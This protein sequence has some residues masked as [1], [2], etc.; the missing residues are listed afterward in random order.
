MND[1]LTLW[2]FRNSWCDYDYDDDEIRFLFGPHTIANMSGAPLLNSISCFFKDDDAYRKY[3]AHASNHL[4]RRAVAGSS[5]TEVSDDLVENDAKQSVRIADEESW[6]EE[7]A[8][9]EDSDAVAGSSESSP[10][11]R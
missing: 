7:N 3:F 9:D 6:S 10:T 1:F 11:D 2:F 4:R 8:V 5:S